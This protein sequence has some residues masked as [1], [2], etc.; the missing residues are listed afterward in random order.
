MSARTADNASS[1]Y[2]CSKCGATFSISEEESICPVCGFNCS[3]GGCQIVD[4]SDE[5]Y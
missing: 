3:H 1:S 4:A 5:G 2:K